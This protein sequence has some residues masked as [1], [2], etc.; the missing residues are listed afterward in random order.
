MLVLFQ[1]VAFADK[2]VLGLVASRAIPDLGISSVE[3]GFIGSAFFFLYAVASILAGLAATRIAIRW[4]LLTLGL[5][6]A[7]MQ[8]PILLGGG[9]AVLLVTRIILG[10]AEGPATAI[11]LTSAHSWFAPAKRALPSNLIATGSTLGPVIAAP[12]LTWVIIAW[13]WRWAFG[14]L[15][16]AGLVWVAA[17]FVFGGDGPYGAKATGRGPK[18][19]PEQPAPADAA[20]PDGARP[21]PIFRVFLSAAFVAALIGGGTNFFVQGFLTTWLP[22]YLGTVIGLSLGA[23][24][25]V[26]IIPW[27][28][29]AAVLIGLGFLGQRLLKRG[30]TAH[31]AIAIP[32]GIASLV[33]GVAFL[34]VQFTSGALAV[35]LLSIGAGC[36][37]IYPMVATAMAYSVGPRQR[38]LV[39]TTLG[40][41]ASLGAMVSPTLV[42]AL[43]SAAGYTTPAKGESPSVQAA[44]AMAT[45]VHQAFTMT[46]V[47][48]LIGGVLCIAF[49]RPERL[50][51]RLQANLRQNERSPR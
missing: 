15:G 24:G 45:G 2:A 47:L 13:G 39:L 23:V 49:L 1:I 32:F 48:L 46:G 50:G 43:M 20:G 22:Q 38:A 36:S 42:G 12:L 26:T 7:L 6:W 34:L 31:T 14:V 10:G 17:W 8:F 18:S 44:A 40:A 11:S 9:V 28:L 16:I 29:G 33:A 41:A 27:F 5:I 51:A 30:G 4:I 35:A 3:F 25:T 21:V 19:A 37:L